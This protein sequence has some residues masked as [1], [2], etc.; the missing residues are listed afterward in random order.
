MNTLIPEHP[1]AAFGNGGVKPGTPLIFENSKEEGEIFVEIVFYPFG[2]NETKFDRKTRVPLT[3]VF[4]L[5][6]FF[7]AATRPYKKAAARPSY[8][9]E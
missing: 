4:N 8:F 2:R 7:R 6:S 5:K 1:F 9:L 3:R